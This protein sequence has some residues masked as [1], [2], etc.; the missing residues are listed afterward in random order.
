MSWKNGCAHFS[1]NA[2]A[3]VVLKQNHLWTRKVNVK[4]LF[5]VYSGEHLGSTEVFQALHLHRQGFQ[6]LNFPPGLDF[7]LL[8]FVF[9]GLTFSPLSH[10]FIHVASLLL[11][12]IAINAPKEKDWCR[13]VCWFAD[14]LLL[15]LLES[16]MKDVHS[17]KLQH[18]S[19]WV[20][21]WIMT[22][23][24]YPK[25]VDLCPAVAGPH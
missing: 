17:R 14:L 15:L 16:C 1:L 10:I 9:M 13:V 23:V 7:D 12:Q 22:S 20:I 19:L 8:D 6:I 21:P 24:K 11:N 25:L 3:H 5:F 2:G 4:L 18:S